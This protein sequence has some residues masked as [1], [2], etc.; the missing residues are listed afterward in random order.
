MSRILFIDAN[1]Y[2]D[3]FRT[4]SGKKV[5]DTVEEQQKY[6]FVT[7]QI[8]NEV[9]RNKVRVAASFLATQQ[10]NLDGI[11]VPD[12]LLST[13]DSTVED[14]RK[15]LHKIGTS[16]GKTKKDFRK[17]ADDLLKQV[18]RSEDE[19]S[20]RLGP[21]FSQAATPDREEFERAIYRKRLGH[22]PGKKN[23]TLGDQISWEQLLTHCKAKDKPKLWIITR[24]SDYATAHDGKM[25]LNAL[26]YLELGNLYRAAPDVF[27][28]NN[29]PDAIKHFSETERVRAD[30]LPTPEETKQIKEEQASLPRLDWLNGY[31]D[32]GF[33][34]VQNVFRSRDS[35]MLRA[36]LGSQIVSEE[37]I[38]PIGPGDPNEKP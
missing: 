30:K 18:S 17:L 1:L 22:P 10:L 36:A 11:A 33:A 31:D 12:H 8:V 2:L 3:L 20:K 26:L 6:I 23:D 19:V 38:F 34:A 28:F 7:T 9:Q 25:Y 21:L 35:E 29:I 13:T 37:T 5:L 27:C 24:D 32:G 14:M 4:V 15:Q 16:V